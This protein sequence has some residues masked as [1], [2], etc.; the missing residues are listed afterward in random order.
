MAKEK[1]T[2]QV[3]EQD[4]KMTKGELISYGMGGVASTMASQFRTSYAMNFLSDVAGLHVGAVGI[5]S[6][7]MLIWDATNDLII[8]R[9]ADRTNTKRF[10]KYRPHMMMGILLWA[11]V[12]IMLFSVPSLPETGMW[13]Y[14]IVAL[15]LYATFYTQFTVPWQ[16]LNSV[17]THDP[18]ERNLLLT[19]R[20][21]GGFIA[22]AVV[23]VITMPL[24]QHFE[25]PKTG[26]LAS[27]GVVCVT[28]IVTGLLSAHG[29]RRVDY[30][31]SLPTPEPF[32]WKGQL[33]II[34]KNRAV[35]CASLMLGVV[36]L[37]NAT[38]SATSLYYLGSVVGSTMLKS[39]F[40]LVTLGVS[41]V[42]IPVMPLILHK[43]GKSR[44]VLL[45]MVIVA[46]PSILLFI[47]REHL[48]VAEI[49]FNSF[50]GSLG[51][52]MANVGC[53]A[54]IPDCTDYTEWKFGTV[55]AGFVNSVITFMRQF[56]SA[57]PTTIVGVA[58]AAVN[59]NTD[60]NSQAVV[61]VI[62]NIKIIYPV[63]LLIATV[64]ILKFY[65]LT[66]AFAKQMRAE[67]KE[68]RAKAAQASSN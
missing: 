35:I 46:L 11:A 67:L 39:V 27:A 56:A 58:L 22:G 4:R 57:L 38:T 33:A 26:W 19:S 64:I 52:V 25:D 7:V 54:M 18:Q 1:T 40:S 23:G 9:I 66:P 55:Q 53:L 5:L 17:M 30:Y 34:F 44:T 51:F 45:G 16:A 63:I 65:P 60:P 37:V 28:M 15:F 31:N 62:L 32:R 24:V 50:L 12:V 3:S 59:Y 47:R 48:T 36:T 20:Q 14:Y 42:F 2:P 49:I 29:A 10:G 41:L 6:T 8:G 68:R 21:Y 13:I 61:D 43:F